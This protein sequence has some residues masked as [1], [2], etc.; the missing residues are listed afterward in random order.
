MDTL[1]IVLLQEGGVSGE[2]LLAALR[3]AAIEGAPR[4]VF[5]REALSSVL[6]G[7]PV[8]VLIATAPTDT[9]GLAALK[10]ARS[11]RPDL[12]FI[13]VST[14]PAVEGAVDLLKAGAADYLLMSHLD[15]LASAVRRALD[16][17][18]S[19]ADCRRADLERAH[20]GRQARDEN[21]R[22]DELLA[23]I[24]HDL[25]TPLNA[26]LGWTSMLRSHRLDEAGR[27]RAIE[28]IDRSARKQARMISDIVDF[29]QILTGRLRL[30]LQEVEVVPILAAAIEALRSTAEAKDI[31]IAASLDPAAGVLSG[32]PGRLHQVFWN[33]VSNAI[34][35]TQRGGR[36]DVRLVCRDARVEIIVSDTGKGIRADSLHQIFDRFRQDDR[37]DSGGDA[38]LG[39]GLPIVQ[40]VVEA[41]GGLVSATSAGDG[42]GSTFTV[43]LPV[44]ASALSSPPSLGSATIWREGDPLS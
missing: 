43:V 30:E 26:M 33:L 24:S 42:L 23:R 44:M 25:R 29:S 10:I 36:V 31:R 18:R 13:F 39:L 40:Y 11:V 4:Y 3:E 28:S 8:D 19:R 27:D 14:F 21:R 41:H 20:Q 35:F 6:T 34:R 7:G 15:R 22:R 5:Q 38:G 2:T 9:E 12:P 32:D 16:D 1:S 37:L 17:A